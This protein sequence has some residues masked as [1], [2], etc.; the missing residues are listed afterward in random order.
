MKTLLIAIA[1]LLGIST[2]YADDYEDSEKSCERGS[3]YGCYELGLYNLLGLDTKKDPEKGFKFLKKSCELNNATGC[4]LLAD[5][6]IKGDGT[7]KDINKGI[8]I[9]KMLCDNNYGASCKQ[10]N[11]LLKSRM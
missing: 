2:T 9:Y 7:D 10:Y 11:D 6:Y 4:T 1:F 3:G 5:C 8:E